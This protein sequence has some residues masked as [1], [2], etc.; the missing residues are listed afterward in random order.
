MTWACGKR[1]WMATMMA[2]TSAPPPPPI[3]SAALGAASH[4]LRSFH[5]MNPMR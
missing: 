1:A 5:P 3:D 4:V 2:A